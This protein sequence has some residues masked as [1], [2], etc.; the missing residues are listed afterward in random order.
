MADMPRPG[1]IASR[2]HATSTVLVVEDEHDIADFLRAYFRASGYALVHVD[3]DSVDDVVAAVE[4]VDPACVLLDLHLRGFSGLDSYRLLRDSACR[5]SSHRG[6]A[7]CEVRDRRANGDTIRRHGNR[8]HRRPDLSIIQVRVGK[9]GGIEPGCFG[10]PDCRDDV[11]NRLRRRE[12]DAK[13]QGL[14]RFGHD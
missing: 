4:K 12:S 2:L 13:P 1:S 7:S 9:P 8:A 3:P 14:F 11:P 5:G 10:V 6:V